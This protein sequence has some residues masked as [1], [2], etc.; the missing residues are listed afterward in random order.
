MRRHHRFVARDLVC[1]A[2]WI[3]PDLRREAEP[4]KAQIGCEARLIEGIEERDPALGK[5]A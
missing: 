5:V 1:F 2:L 3:F 4:M